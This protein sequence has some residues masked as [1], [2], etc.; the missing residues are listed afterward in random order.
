MTVKEAEERIKK[1][2]D[3]AYQVIESLEN[4]ND[5]MISITVSAGYKN[6]RMYDK[7]NKYEFIDVFGKSE[8]DNDK[9]RV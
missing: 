2:T 7:I 5:L 9:I 8:I 3:E 4:P 6:Y 1:L